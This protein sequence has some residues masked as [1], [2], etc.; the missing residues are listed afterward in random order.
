MA[1]QTE[2]NFVRAAVLVCGALL[3]VLPAVAQTQCAPPPPPAAAAGGG[4]GKAGHAAGKEVKELKEQLNLTPDQVKTIKAAMEEQM[5]KVKAAREDTTMDPKAKRKAAMAAM[6]DGNA[7]IK[8]VLTD[9]QKPKYDA[10]V[11]QRREEMKAR[12]G[13]AGAPPADGSAPPPPPPGV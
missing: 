3:T 10:W 2:K 9:D 11:A 6:A 5:E 7:K 4:G 12:H 1:T 13:G 8:A